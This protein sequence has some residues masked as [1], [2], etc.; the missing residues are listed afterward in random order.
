MEKKNQEVK[1]EK[2]ISQWFLEVLTLILVF[3][4]LFPGSVAND[5]SWWWIT[6]PLWI[7]PLTMVAMMILTFVVIFVS[8]LF[9]AFFGVKEEK[10]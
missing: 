1:V 4:K 9:L 5:W 6:S 10:D 7:P 2:V 8:Q 3:M